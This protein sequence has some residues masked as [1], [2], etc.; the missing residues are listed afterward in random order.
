MF[1][2]KKIFK[3]LKFGVLKPKAFIILFSLF[4]SSLAFAAALSVTW[5]FNCTFNSS[6]VMPMVISCNISGNGTHNLS[7]DRTEGS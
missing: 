2:F 1:R 6:E 4:F 3:D 7:N 5:T